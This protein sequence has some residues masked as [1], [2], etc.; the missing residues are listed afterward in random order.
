MTY[1]NTAIVQKMVTDVW[2]LAGMCFAY[3]TA[4]KLY[5]KIQKNNR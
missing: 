1:V 2:S 4:L 3:M 5:K